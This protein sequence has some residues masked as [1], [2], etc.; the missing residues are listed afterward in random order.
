MSAIRPA[1][2]A[3]VLFAASACK[4]SPA[5]VPL[6]LSY[7]GFDGYHRAVTT[8]N[9][10][11]QR[12]VDQG[13][14][15]LYGYNHDEAIRTFGEAARV[16]PDCAMAWWG[17]AYAN[18]L[19]INNPKMSE[20]QSKAA[21]DAAQE[22]LRCIPFAS[23]SETALI[24]AV[25]ERYAWPVPEDRGPLDQ[26]YADAMQAAYAAHADDPDV[27]AL[28]AESLMN[29]QPWDLW[30]H[31][32]E[33]KGRVL[34]IVDVLEH[35][36]KISPKHPGANHFYIHTVEASR[37]PERAVPAADRLVDLVPGSGH[38][39][40][41]PSHVYA[42]V[43]RYAD[44]ADAN[45]RAIAADRAYFALAPEPD[46]YSLYYLHNVHFLAYAA[47]MECRPTTALEAARSIE[48]DAPAAFLRDFV[49]F[50]DGLMPTLFHVQI[51]FGMWEEILAEPEPPAWRM[52]SRAMRHYARGVAF[53]ALGRTDEAAGE[54]AAFDE[55]AARVPEDWTIGNNA[56]HT[57]LPLAR[58]MLI[59][60][61]RFREGKHDEAFAA[62]RRAAREEDGLVYG[63]PPGWMQPVRHALG[64][65]LMS[66]GR[67]DEAAATYRTDLDRNPENG[68][69]LLGLE[70]ALR[71]NGD[72]EGASAA[73]GR[74]RAAWKRAEVQPTSS[75][76]C[77]PGT[78]EVGS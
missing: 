66:A 27:G 77:E 21:Y 48:T 67:Y 47:M 24:R 61:L 74:R 69:S 32:G 58:G 39:V 11:A 70:L 8:S 65:L 3:V 53:S 9:P 75:C 49:Q 46:F 78:A 42:R 17:I 16:D 23:P 6:A 22:A 15:L 37:S 45:E 54:L 51:R 35:V 18:G 64:A 76:Y 52:L 14:Q 33:P 1:L 71:A 38:L 41:M 30:T 72:N 20:A 63:E 29:L 36:M 59:G 5:E 31:A 68:W 40:H 55:V 12:W 56:A 26:A 57:V 4:S 44:A 43:G 60:E 7:P 2:L 50:A 34:E 28:Y 19:H 13:V 10:E 73:L 62:L 25:A